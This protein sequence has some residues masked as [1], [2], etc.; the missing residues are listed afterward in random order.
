[1]YF[2]STSVALF[3][4]KWAKGEFSGQRLGQ[5]FSNHFKLPST[6]QGQDVNSPLWGLW[7]K[8]GAEAWSVI[9]LHIDWDN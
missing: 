5:A 1:M 8:D 3:H 4:E 9:N 6:T 7:N 2:P